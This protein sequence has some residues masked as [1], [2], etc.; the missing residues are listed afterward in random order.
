MSL[1][2]ETCEKINELDE[3]KMKAARER[4][5]SLI[6][7]P[8]S[9]GKLEELAE[10]LSGITGELYPDINNRVHILMAGDH[11]VAKEGV[12]IAP[13]ALT[14]SMMESFLTGGAAINVFCRQMDAELKV[15]DMG[16]A[17]DI[18]DENIIDQKIKYA[19]GNISREPAMSEKEAIES[20]ETGIELAFQAA[21]EGADI[22]ST[23]EMGI[24]NTTPS[25][26]VL[27]A[28]TDYEVKEVV[29]YG[30]GINDSQ[31]EKKINI[32]ERAISQNQPD[33]NSAVDVLAAVGGLE[34]GGMAGVMLGAAARSLPVLVDGFISGAAAMLAYGIQPDVTGYLIPSHK[35]VEPGHIKIYE[36]LGLSPM[37]DMDMRLGEGTGAVLALPLVESA[38]RMMRDMAT[39]SEAGIELG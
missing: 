24:G 25:S 18:E 13:Q 7:P 3:E 35:S 39:F 17:E 9:L 12:S 5:N 30:T 22:I 1:L 21:D 33:P 38:V 14:A 19:T 8:G 36:H 37:L 6:K 23:G 4:I 10:K 34:I 31:R 15:V 2:Q 16:L 32:V 26:A 29:G 27:A 28:M 20:L 11:G